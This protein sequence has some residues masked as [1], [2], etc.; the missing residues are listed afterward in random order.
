MTIQLELSKPMFGEVERPI[1]VMGDIRVSGFR[2]RSGVEA[3]RLLTPRADIVVL[4]FKGQQIWRAV[5]DGRDLTMRSMFA[6][7]RATEVYLETYGAFL[8]HCG[9]TAMGV[10]GPDDRHPLHGELPNAPMDSACLRL[11]EA[12]ATVTV[13]SRYQHTVA[14]TANYVATP[15]ITLAADSTQLAVSVAV[16]NLRRSPMELM[17]LAHA[18]FR[19]VDHGRLIYAAPYTAEA[20]RVRTSIPGHIRPPPDY[21][22]FIAALDRDPTLHHRLDPGQAFDPEVVFTLAMLADADGWTHAIQQHPEGNADFI[23]FRPDQAPMATRWICRTADQDGLGIAFPTTA[24]VE[25]YAIEKAKG[26][27]VEVAAEGGWRIDMRMGALAGGDATAMVD[28]IERITG[29]G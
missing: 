13:S 15:E 10:P 1:A 12:A 4:P 25:G 21:A 24:G 27:L 8:L 26:R 17:Y 16:R 19:P 7:P 29:R 28:R 18:N 2:Y 20:V 14:F 3:L 5:F 22:E 11:D 23:S 6:E 9:L